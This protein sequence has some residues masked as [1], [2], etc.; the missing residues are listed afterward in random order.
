MHLSGCRCL[1]LLRFVQE[2]GMRIGL[3]GLR[4]MK[5]PLS[6]NDSKEKRLVKRAL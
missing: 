1:W 5:Q 2:R 3:T 4:P 6:L